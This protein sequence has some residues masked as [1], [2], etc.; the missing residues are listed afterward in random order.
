MRGLT[1]SHVH[2][3]FSD[4]EGTPDELVASAR[5]RGLDELG[6]SDHLVPRRLDLDG[7]GM[8]HDGIE[9]YLRAVREAGRRAP[10]GLRVLAGVEVDFAPDTV[11]ETDALLDAHEFDY[12][13]CSVHHVD[14]F[15]FDLPETLDDE[16]WSDPDALF[17]RYF[18]L[19]AAAAASGRYDV[20]GHLDLPAKF[21]RLPA[22]DLSACWAAALDAIAAAGMAVE[23]NTGGLHDPIGAVYPDERILAAARERGIAIV[24]GSDAH[25]PSQV[26]R[27]FDAAVALA[28][29]AGYRTYRRLSDRRDVPLPDA[30][31][32]LDVRSPSVD[33]R[34]LDVPPSGPPSPG[35]AP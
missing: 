34:Q 4:G 31:P 6:I 9:D 33:R 11:A 23:L 18:E 30:P 29:R 5:A 7:Y 15:P 19:I 27:D 32:L 2:T 1:D 8:S 13:I 26:G 3:S 16:R 25:D 21:G 12:V 14:G 28:W 20:A 35:V 17:R 24:F 22:G 10:G